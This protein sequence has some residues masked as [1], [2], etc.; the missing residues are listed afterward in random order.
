MSE[1]CKYTEET[2]CP[3]KFDLLFEK[4]DRLDEAIRGNGKPGILMRLDRLEQAEIKRAKLVWL[5]VGALLA[6]LAGCLT[7]LLQ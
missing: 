6:G 2:E 5:L 4:I 7:L 1:P 3:R